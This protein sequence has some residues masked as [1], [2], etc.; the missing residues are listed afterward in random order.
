MNKNSVFSKLVNITAKG[1]FFVILIKQ[2]EKSFTSLMFSFII[3]VF[4]VE[5]CE[6]YIHLMLI[7]C[8]FRIF[9]NTLYLK[10]SFSNE[11]SYNKCS[12]TV[13]IVIRSL[14]SRNLQPNPIFS[15]MLCNNFWSLPFVIPAVRLKSSRASS[16]A[17][18]RRAFT[19]L[20][21]YR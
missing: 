14:R 6:Q 19:F 7:V 11:R 20:K 16:T 21:A 1:F 9:N 18:P 13:F 4:Q 17:N 2:S 12:N 10:M 15:R 5:I 8:Q 3:S